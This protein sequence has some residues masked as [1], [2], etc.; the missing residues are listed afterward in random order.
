MKRTALS[1]F[2]LPLAALTLA[3]CTQF[4]ELEHTQTAALD[5]AA[6]PDLVPVEPILAQV[7]APHTDPVQTQAGMEARLSRLRARADRLRA[8]GMSPEER[9]RLQQGLR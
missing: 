9:R 3:A 5:A 2:L 8:Q 7:D 1:R 4:P 6:Y